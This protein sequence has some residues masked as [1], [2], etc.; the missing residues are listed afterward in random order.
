LIKEATSR[1][2]LSYYKLVDGTVSDLILGSLLAAADRGVTVR[3]LL[4]GVIQLAN[5]NGR[6]DDIFLGFTSHPNIDV[7]LYE[8]FSLLLPFSW[9]N[10]LHDKMILVDDRFALVGGRNIEDRFYLKER[11]QDGFTH[12][13][14]VLVYH[15]RQPDSTADGL[16]PASAITDMSDYFEGL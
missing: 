5:M 9:N 12:D 11:Y 14:D 4:D 3:I 10:R 8:P 15:Q 7:R 1:I 13:R 6:V 16:A 2:D